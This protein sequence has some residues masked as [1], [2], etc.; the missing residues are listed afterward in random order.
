VDASIEGDTIVAGR[1]IAFGQVAIPAFDD[2][3]IDTIA[4]AAANPKGN[5]ML[6]P[7][8]AARLLELQGRI[9]GGE[10]LPEAEQAE[11]DALQALNK[12]Y[13]SPGD[14]PAE[15]AT[16]SAAKPATAPASAPV[17][18]AASMPA[19]PGGVASRPP[20]TTRPAGS[21]LRSMVRDVTAALAPSLRSAASISAALT[22]VTHGDHT[23]NIE[24]LA[25]SGELWS[26]LQ[27]A[28][29]WSDLFSHDSLTNWEGKGWRFT[30]TPEMQDY[31]GDK[32]E[33]PSGTVVTEDSSYEAARMAVGVDVDRKFYDFPNE[34]F[35]SGLFERVRESWE[36]KLDAK[37][38]AY[39]LAQ[40]VAGTRTLVVSTTN[41]DATVEAPNHS[42]TA[43]DVGATVTG[44][45]IPASTTILSVTDHNT[46]ELSANATATGTPTI[47]I[48]AQEGTVLKAAA[49]AALVLKN[50]R[51]GRASFVMLNDEDMFSLMDVAED[52]VPAFLS[53][54]NIEPGNFRSSPDV[55]RGTVVSGVSQAATIRTLPGSPIRVSAQNL[56][57]G[58]IDEAF[59]GY[60]AIEEHHTSGIVTVKFNP[61]A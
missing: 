3:R 9:D 46:I 44:T 7:E 48:G 38:K 13:N 47:T 22:D 52:D 39:A 36:I 23:E 51:V 45:G 25:W 29:I 14:A 20:A 19:V 31:A 11:Y 2:T 50:R 56:A 33:I 59:F 30:T 41:A 55:P 37:V 43:S 15:T 32:A 34:G 61:A 8:Q 21:A 24:P 26:G 40:A 35:V 16:A 5:A 12:V 42:F 1:V 54:Y 4:A 28:P 27:Y 60:W 6:S 17:Q 53:L 18:V 57:N 58:G 10:S 49:R